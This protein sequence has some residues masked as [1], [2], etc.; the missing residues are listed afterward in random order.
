MDARTGLEPVHATDRGHHDL[1]DGFPNVLRQDAHLVEHG[2]DFKGTLAGRPGL[3]EIPVAHILAA[4]VLGEP[5]RQAHDHALGG[6]AIDPEVKPHAILGT[7]A[8]GQLHVYQVCHPLVD[9][10]GI[11][12]RDAVRGGS[13]E[14]VLEQK[15]EDLQAVVAAI[16][17]DGQ[18]GC[19]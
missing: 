13:A 9:V 10:L 5:V 1:S 19:V 14:R 2:L 7:I 17:M 16:H 11:V 6:L 3:V 15:R 8:G 18:A 12:E 4:A